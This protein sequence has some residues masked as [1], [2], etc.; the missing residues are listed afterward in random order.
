MDVAG[1]A[2]AEVLE[3]A[4]TCA[5]S[6]CTSLSLAFVRSLPAAEPALSL[7][8]LAALSFE[9]SLASLPPAGL[10][11]LCDRA[12]PLVDRASS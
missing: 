12:L 4:A 9:G 10:D 8:L 1:D 7:S 11:K 2:E 3:V 6:F 5:M